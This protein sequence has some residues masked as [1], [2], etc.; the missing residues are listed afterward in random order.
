MLTTAFAP[1]STTAFATAFTTA[2][3]ALL[4]TLTG[5]GVQPSDAIEAG[6]PPSGAVEPSIAI[7]LY[8]VRDDKLTA[9]TRPAGGPLFPQDTLALL[10]AGPTARERSRGYTTQVPAR[11]GPFSV[12]A[13]PAGRLIVTLSTPADKLSTLATDQIICTATTT[14]P[15]NAT[16]VTIIGAGETIGPRTCPL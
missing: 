10:A 12:T 2:F 1:A 11:A 9:V 4:L 14:T 7:T 15:D 3:A 13:A 8:F 16:Q 6:D 5:C